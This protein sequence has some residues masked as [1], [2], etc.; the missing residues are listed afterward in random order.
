VDGS[1]PPRQ[2]PVK[3]QGAVQIQNNRNTI[4]K[5]PQKYMYFLHYFKDKLVV[6]PATVSDLKNALR[7]KQTK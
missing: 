6:N 1:V 7:R 4:I 5:I 2:Q 3:L